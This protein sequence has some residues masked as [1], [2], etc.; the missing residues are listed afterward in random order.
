MSNW[1][2]S[3]KISVEKLLPALRH[4]LSNLVLPISFYCEALTELG[5]TDDDAK[6]SLLLSTE[7]LSRL[8]SLISLL[9]GSNSTFKV[10]TE[11]NVL[12]NFRFEDYKE[13]NLVFQELIL[14]AQEAGAKNIDFKYEDGFIYASDDGVP[15]SDLSWL[16]DVSLNGKSGCGLGLA[17]I[18]AF[19]SKKGL[20]LEGCVNSHTKF[21]FSVS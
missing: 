10:S 17:A 21:R 15:I 18:T 4:R 5:G 8:C 16:G 9:S 12:Y 7:G 3:G 6:K 11:I 2:S 13:Y 1:V 20:I 14:N 19:L